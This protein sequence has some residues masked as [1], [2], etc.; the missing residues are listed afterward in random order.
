MVNIFGVREAIRTFACFTDQSPHS[1]LRR[2]SLTWNKAA[3]LPRFRLPNPTQLFLENQ[4]P[5]NRT[6]QPN[7]SQFSLS[8]NRYSTSG[9]DSTKFAVRFSKNAANPSCPSSEA[10]KAASR[11]AVSS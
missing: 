9:T 8:E 3:N 2:K 7:A 5:L 11:D 1:A 10:R 4:N 6:T